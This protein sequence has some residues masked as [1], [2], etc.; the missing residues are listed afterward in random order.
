MLTMREGQDL[1]GFAWGQVPSEGG[2]IPGLKSW[3]FYG[4]D[5]EE[6][7][8]LQAWTAKDFL[9]VLRANLPDLTDAQAK[10]CTRITG[11]PPDFVAEVLAA[12]A[13]RE[14]KAQ[15]LAALIASLEDDE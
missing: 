11:A 5:P 7:D 2:M 14:R 4:P 15:E 6:R 13:R 12:K 1:L 9:T 10:C 3:V 8:C